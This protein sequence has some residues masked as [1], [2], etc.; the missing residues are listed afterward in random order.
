MFDCV[1]PTRNGRHGKL[2]TSR[3]AVNIRAAQ[4]RGDATPLDATTHA[5]CAGVT[6][7][8]LHH[9]FRCHETLAHTL[10]SLHNLFYYQLLMQQMRDAIA[11]GQFAAFVEEFNQTTDY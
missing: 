1:L 11:V 6:R 2:F 5:E 9:L 7:G 4:Y 3:G 8:Y 10:A